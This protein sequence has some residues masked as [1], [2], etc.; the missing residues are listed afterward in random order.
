MRIH[1]SQL[2]SGCMVT[3]DIMGKTN[4]PIIPKNTVIKPIHMTVLHKFLVNE[5]E[6]AP[7]L[8]SGEAFLPEHAIEEENMD[9]DDH[10]E[11]QH[12][13]FLNLYL[14]AVQKYKNMFKD[15]Q[16][17]APIN[18]AKV[19]NLLVPLIEKAH[20]NK[21]KV[22]MLHHYS[23]K[24]NYFYHHSIAVGLL[25]AVIAHQLKYS[26]G[27]IIQVG[28]TG[29]L[30]D[31]GMAKIDERILF[32][33]APLVT[34]EFEEIKKHPTY[35]YRLVENIPVLKNSVRLGVL[36]HH[37]RMDGSGYPIGLNS[38]KL[39]PY[40]KIVAVCD[41][42]HAMTSERLYRSKQSPFMVIEELMQDQFGKFDH[43]V[44]QALIISMTNYSTGTHVRLSNNQNAE[45]IFMEPK[46]PTR[47]MV[48]LQHNEE[49][50]HL[51][52]HSSLFIEEILT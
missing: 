4:Q 47:P 50:I 9:Q 44:V 31:C 22:F 18:I 35:S 25:S 28:L 36:Q 41:L 39:N 7:K 10:K 24:E 6:V 2:V 21:G 43:I 26:H 34:P 23:T 19:R 12:I 11:E 48:R 27:E 13:P 45:I 5:V 14:E 1:P 15:W 32:K 40:G 3:T 42:Y 29:F 30:S 17:G 37:E 49:I 46:L 16:S 20:E 38:S 8:A 51:K 33:K 52:D